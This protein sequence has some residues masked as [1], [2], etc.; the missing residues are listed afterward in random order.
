MNETPLEIF[1]SLFEDL[2]INR[3]L[4]D[5]KSITD[6]IPV[7]DPKLIVAEY[8]KLK[9]KKEFNLNDFFAANFKMQV[10]EDVNFESN[11]EH[12]PDEH[13]R[14][15][16]DHLK[17]SDEGK[18]LDLTLINLP[19]PYVVPGGRFNEVYYWDSFF[20]MLGLGIHGQWG[21]VENMLDNF[22]WL[23]RQYGFIPNGNRSYFLSRSQPPFYSLMVNLLAGAQGREIY[24]KYKISLLKEYRFWSD[25]GH[26]DKI[27]EKRIAEHRI[28]VYYDKVNKPRQE[29]YADDLELEQVVGNE[30]GKLFQ[31]LRSA[32]ESGWDF[33]S[34]W[35]ADFQSLGTIRTC[36]LA[37]IDLQCLLFHLE[38]TLIKALDEEQWDIV[39]EQ[40]TSR[41]EQRRKTINELFWNKEESFYTDFN[42]AENKAVNHCN[43]SGVFPLYFNIADK[44]KAKRVKQKIETDFLKPGGV[45]TSLIDS[46]QQWDAPNGW[47]PL[48]WMTIKGLEN[49]GF[50]RLAEEIAERWTTLNESVYAQ[51]GAF[52]EKYNVEDL[53][54]RAGGGEYDLQD[55][56]GWSN[57]VYVALKKYLKGEMIA[58]E[59]E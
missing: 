51:T 18:D 11:K 55:G 48:Q 49:Y 50:T 59:E 39:R 45:V 24:D 58:L 37:P 47:A 13:I 27:H 28:N 5:G 6:A 3:V 19:H 42:I 52:V 25:I 12:S 15:L 7:N 14:N 26:E 56:F 4:S 1:G 20:T 31:H 57:G 32:C 9:K 35:F 10:D 17:R 36:D 8:K 41:M 53:T 16:W 44:K 21:I 34:R 46:G 23:I 33:S 2:H 43:L 54:L 22:D 29:M 38:E 30:E 40:L